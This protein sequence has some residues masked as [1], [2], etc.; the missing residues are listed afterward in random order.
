MKRRTVASLLLILSS[1]TFNTAKVFGDD[2]TTLTV[3]GRIFRECTVNMPNE[4]SF[5]LGEFTVHDW[6]ANQSGLSHGRTPEFTFTLTGCGEN[7]KI[8]VSATG[9]AVN[10][11]DR[12]SWLANQS[13]SAPE[14][15]ASL[16]L[17][18]ADGNVI[19]LILNS[20]EGHFY[21]TTVSENTP[22]E[23]T[24]KGLLSRTDNNN[25]PIGTYRAT[26]IVNFE[27]F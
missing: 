23:V 19:P 26:M 5:A 8:Y 9:T 22:I 11:T 21:M 2:G 25:T 4:G 6:V 16:E 15:A 3:S 13:G 17:V 14:L 27:F 24:L 10:T 20:A 1:I 12:S 7:V 18:K